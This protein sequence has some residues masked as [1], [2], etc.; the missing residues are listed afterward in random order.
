MKHSPVQML[1][2]VAGALQT[3]NAAPTDR[4]YCTPISVQAFSIRKW[5]SPS[6]V[7][8]SSCRR[9][10]AKPAPRTSKR[11]APL[12]LCGYASAMMNENAVAKSRPPYST[13]LRHTKVCVAM[14]PQTL[15]TRGRGTGVAEKCTPRDT[16]SWGKLQFVGRECALYPTPPAV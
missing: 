1:S 8:N 5:E 12:L 7:I 16:A 4:L 11:Q 10:T 9:C 13:V 14:S 2:P 6:A 15:R 3:H